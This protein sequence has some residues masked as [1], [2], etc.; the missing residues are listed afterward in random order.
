MKSIPVN[1]C[2]GDITFMYDI[3]D[4][5][6]KRLATTSPALSDKHSA[7]ALGNSILRQLF[8]VACLPKAIQPKREEQNV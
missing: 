3:A 1:L 8:E 7:E 4:A 6:C 2:N 5:V